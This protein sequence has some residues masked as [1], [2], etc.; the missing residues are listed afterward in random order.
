VQLHE[1]AI[2]ERLDR[3]R[4]PQA[5][6]PRHPFLE[7]QEAA[8][9]SAVTGL[10]QRRDRP[11][12]TD[13][14]G[15]HHKPKHHKEAPKQPAPDIHGRVV[16]IDIDHDVPVITIA[17]GSDHGVKVG[18]PGSMVE[19]GKEIAD[20]TIET[21]T[22]AWSTAHVPQTTFDMLKRADDAV[23]KASQFHE[24]SQEGKEF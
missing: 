18:M 16:K 17:K 12:S 6:S 24:E 20:F 11:A 22:G 21:V 3:Q 5:A 2:A 9:N 1:Q 10:I 7:L 8:G 4:R 13:A 23:I 14:P 15:A 19:N